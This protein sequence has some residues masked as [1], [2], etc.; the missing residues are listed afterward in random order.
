MPEVSTD[1]VGG[2]LVGVPGG[3]AYLNCHS[4]GFRWTTNRRDAV[5]LNSR[6]DAAFLVA[7]L[8]RVV[9]GLFTKE[10]QTVAPRMWMPD[11]VEDA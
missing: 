7:A 5:R 8:Q 4:G 10:A 9:P 2:W 1:A 11:I 3:S 6:R